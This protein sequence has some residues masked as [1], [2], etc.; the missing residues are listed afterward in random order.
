MLFAE[1]QFVEVWEFLN[2]LTEWTPILLELMIFALPIDSL[3]LFVI[4]ADP[5]EQLET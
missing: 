4:G 1:Y 5:H 3:Q 2:H